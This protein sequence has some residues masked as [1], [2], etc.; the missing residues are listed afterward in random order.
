MIFI[1]ARS[2]RG[3]CKNRLMIKAHTSELFFLLFLIAFLSGCIDGWDTLTRVQDL[4]F[5]QAVAAINS[6][7]GVA[8]TRTFSNNGPG[9]HTFWI[10][11]KRGDVSGFIAF[12]DYSRKQAV[13][14][15][16]IQGFPFTPKAG[17]LV[18][19]IY[20]AIHRECPAVTDSPSMFPLTRGGM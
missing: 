3:S 5:E 1:D 16:E 20:E 12:N 14:N 4:S 2:E 19:D 13:G 18:G 9:Y 8:I 17:R 7:P 11:V 15:L 10:A 6:M